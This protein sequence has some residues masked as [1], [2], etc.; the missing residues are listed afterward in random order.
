[1]TTH[2]ITRKDIILAV[3]NGCTNTRQIADRLQV[4]HGTITNYFYEGT[5]I[6]FENGPLLQWTPKKANTLR[7]GSNV[8]CRRRADG[9]VVDVFDFRNRY[10]YTCD[11]MPV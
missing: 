2:K 10:D 11:E 3:A 5:V 6:R 1:M 7:L 4:L 8:L 9:L